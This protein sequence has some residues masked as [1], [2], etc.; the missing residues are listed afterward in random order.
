VSGSVAALAIGVCLL[1]TL[2][3]GM[4]AQAVGR[5]RRA[6]AQPARAFASRGQVHE[7]NEDLDAVRK[8]IEEAREELVWLREQVVKERSRLDQLK[9]QAQ[10]MG[11]GQAYQ[12]PAGF[13][14]GPFAQQPTPAPP[15]D[16]PWVILGLRPGSSGE[17]IRRR[18]RLLSRVWHPD[19]FADGPPELRAEAERMMA[20]LNRAHATLS[21]QTAVRR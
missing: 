2:L 10:G 13:G 9:R 14:P 20:R 21:T 1:V 16:S 19:R 11:N 3:V 4:A 5:S 12:Q 17:D 6:L 8:S 18:Y 7:T 15:F